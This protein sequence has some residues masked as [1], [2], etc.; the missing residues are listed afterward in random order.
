MT[1]QPIHGFFFLLVLIKSHLGPRLDDRGPRFFF[2]RVF[3]FL[4]WVLI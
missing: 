2:M 3:F 1:D 4:K